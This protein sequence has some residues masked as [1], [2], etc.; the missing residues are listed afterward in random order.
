MGRA[1]TKV[2]VPKELAFIN[3]LTRPPFPTI[4]AAGKAAGYDEV[5]SYQLR[6]LPHIDAEI[7][8][9]CALLTEAAAV[10]TVLVLA[11]LAERA[12]T[13]D[14]AARIYLEAVGRIGNAMAVNVTTNVQQE[15][16]ADRIKRVFGERGVLGVPRGDTPNEN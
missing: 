4:A 5:Y 6:H 14:R 8:E 15:P 7:R 11:S 9:R 13:S 12:K 3:A 10:E 2:L 1:K 16:L